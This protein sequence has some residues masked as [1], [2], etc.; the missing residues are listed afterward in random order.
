MV[1]TRLGDGGQAPWTYTRT[2]RRLGV[3]IDRNGG[4][5][6]LRPGTDVL[7]A[8]DR[9]RARKLRRYSRHRDAEDLEQLVLSYL[10]LAHALAR[11][12]GPR[13]SREDLEQV[14]CEG[15]IKAI[16]RFE[17]DRGFAFTTFAIPTILG[18]LRRH[19][20][21]TAWPAH[22]PRPLQ[23]RIQG[24]RSAAER[25]GARCGRE[26]TAAELADVLGCHEEEVLDALTAAASLNVVPLDAPRR[27]QDPGAGPL[28][29]QIGGPDPAYDRVEC[30]ASIE[31][32]AP[33]LSDD[34][35]EVVRLRFSEELTHREIARRLNVSRSE[36]ARR[37]AAA[38]DSLRST[39]QLR[40][41]G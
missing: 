14:A 19:R 23:E 5:T 15:L 26:P 11:R 2:R 22:V 10:P 25:H 17:P 38:E 18:E 20:R 37:L 6:T 28:A 7:V 29:E 1:V 33:A 12:F 16:R 30:L 21:D 41:A 27:D 36:V 3:V 13:G 24:V 31:A 40:L 35:R 4:P 32:A 8:R 39:L 9:E 34:H